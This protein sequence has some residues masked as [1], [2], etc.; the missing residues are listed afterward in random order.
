[1]NWVNDMAAWFASHPMRDREDLVHWAMKATIE[2]AARR[3]EEGV[4]QSCKSSPHTQ[5]SWCAQS[6]MAAHRIR[7]MLTDD[8]PAPSAG[9][10]ASGK[11]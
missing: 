1:M 5:H 3:C 11:E 9:P 6:I 8:S 4:C 7:A 10:T 2:E